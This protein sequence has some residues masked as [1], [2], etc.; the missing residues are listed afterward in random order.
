MVRCESGVVC[1]YYTQINVPVN[2]LNIIRMSGGLMGETGDDKNVIVSCARLNCFTMARRDGMDVE[3]A[4]SAFRDD[5]NN[6]SV[7]SVTRFFFSVV[8]SFG[9]WGYTHNKPL[10]RR[11]G[12]RRSVASVSL[13]ADATAAR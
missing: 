1:A 9:S 11:A 6:I 7:K 2:L 4:C 12:N 3:C 13:T 10:T 5:V 8:R